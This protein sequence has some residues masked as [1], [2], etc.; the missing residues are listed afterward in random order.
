MIYIVRHGE[1]YWNLTNRMQGQTNI[2][3]NET[4]R[5]QA[6][7]AANE[8]SQLNIDKI[9]SSDLLRAK[10]TAEII[11]KKINV[12]IIFDKRLREINYGDLEGKYR[13]D[14]SPD[15]WNEFR[16][17]PKKFNAETP[18]ELYN[19]ICSLL[20]ELPDTNKNILFVT[21][22]GAMRMISYIE[23]NNKFDYENYNR[24]NVKFAN[25][26]ILKLSNLVVPRGVEPLTAP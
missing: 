14:L 6:E 24:M 22:G 20:N 16:A 11:N 18:E 1:T 15:F 5:Q 9:Y 12:T 3:L 7:N 21:H 4:G 23:N 17:D 2:L 13:K 26:E 8:I 25:A 19:R 10:E